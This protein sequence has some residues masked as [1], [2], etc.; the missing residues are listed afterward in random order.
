MILA[1]FDADEIGSAGPHISALENEFKR[2][3]GV[4]EA[5]ALSSG[6]ASLHLALIAL[7]VGKGDEVLAST[8][9]CAATAYAVTCVGAV[10]VFIDSD[11][12]TWNM[13]PNLLDDEL[14]ARARRKRLPKAAIVVDV[15]GQCADYGPIREICARY[16][17]PIIEDAAEALGAI[18][19]GQKAGSF[20]DVGAFSFNG[21]ANIV[22]NNGGMLVCNR[23]DIA[24][25]VRLLVSQADDLPTHEQY[26][27][28]GYDYQMSNLLAAAGRGQLRELEKRIQQQR[29]RFDFYKR[30]LS[31]IPG[32][33][34]M[35]E[36]SRSRST[37]CVACLT[38]APDVFGATREDVS[39]AMETENIETWPIWKPMH[40]QPVFSGCGVRGGAVAEHIYAQGLC[41]PNGANLD[42][43]DQL[44]IVNVIRS[45]GNA[46][47]Y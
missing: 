33:D 13:D 47:P 27:G 34:F 11:R 40:L 4:R 46:A 42:E 26:S 9:T 36:L 37:R 45:V 28:I 30:A 44:R 23:K 3:L 25:R 7:G 5:V 18:H 15:Y 17:L 19:D 12:A 1:A 31:D 32:I 22:A 16:G 8:L 41:L 20:G 39:L 2:L 14:Q 6:T 21:N 29:E 24:Q 35:P 10:P 38:I 43:E